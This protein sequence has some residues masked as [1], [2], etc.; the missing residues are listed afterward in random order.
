MLKLKEQHTR[1]NAYT[2]SLQ[3]DH[4]GGAFRQK[5]AK[6]AGTL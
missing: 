4:E 5:K 3:P 6:L 2:R 1:I